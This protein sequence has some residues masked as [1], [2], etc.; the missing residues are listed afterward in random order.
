LPIVETQA[1]PRSADGLRSAL[2]RAAREILEEPETALDLRKVAERVGKSRTAPY[3]VFGKTESGGG[4]EALR[5]S[6]AAEGHLELVAEVRTAVR[7]GDAASAIVAAATAYVAFAR[8]HPRLFQLMFGSEAAKAIRAS[9]SDEAVREESR[10]I[11][12]AR[13]ELERLF[14]E[15]V[16]FGQHA[17]AVRDGEIYPLTLSAWS[18]VHGAALLLLDGQLG[19]AGVATPAEAA[20]VALRGLL[21]VSARR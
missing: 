13:G 5:L 14:A 10:A 17:G 7:A 6:V 21:Q 9:A 11:V 15:A 3:L 4:L 2:L 12:A 19:S 20:D 18:A 1:P 16:A 8:R